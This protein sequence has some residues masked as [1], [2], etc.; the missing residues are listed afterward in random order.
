MG[1]ALHALRPWRQVDEVEELTA[2][3]RPCWRGFAL[4]HAH[5]ANLGNT[6]THDVERFHQP[7]EP[8]ALHLKRDAHSFRLGSAA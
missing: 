2:L 7:A 5:Q 3:L 4:D 6:P 1:I 8:V